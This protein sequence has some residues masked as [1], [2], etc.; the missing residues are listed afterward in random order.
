MRRA[1]VS[2][3]AVVL[4]LVPA[5]AATAAVGLDPVPVG[6]VAATGT[7]RADPEGTRLTFERLEGSGGVLTSPEGRVED[8]RLSARDVVVEGSTMTMGSATVDGVVPFDLVAEEIGPDAR[9]SATGDGRARLVRSIEVL[10]RR[11]PVSATGRVDAVDGA[12]VVE[13]VSIE[14][15]GPQ[16]FEGL[17]ARTAG[18]LLSLRHEVEGLPEGLQLERASVADDGIR[19]H[20][21]GEDVVLR[22]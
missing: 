7:D 8:L 2:V 4:G 18:R 17:L 5:P 6:A 16:W 9:V 14:I 10:G 12:V 19:V 3:V 20:L 1:L 22:N 21:S 11:I 15:G 13:P